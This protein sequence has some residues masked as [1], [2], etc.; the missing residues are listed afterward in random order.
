MKK[1]VG[2]RGQ[3]LFFGLLVIAFFGLVIG[4]GCKGQQGGGG[5]SL[6][7]SGKVL[8]VVNGNKITQSDLEAIISNLPPR[9]RSFYK[10][11]QAQKQLV[12][13][14][15]TKELLYHEAVKRGID[16]EKEIRNQM[17]NQ[18]R[19]VLIRALLDQVTEERS[20]DDL[21]RKRFE[22]DKERYSKP[23]VKASHI[24]I[25][26]Q[27]LANKVYQRAKKG[28]NFSKL[29]KEFSQDPSNKNKGGDLGFFP[30]ERMVKEFS[31]KAFNMKVGEI[32]EPVKTRYGYHIIKLT[33]KRESQPFEEVKE[34][35]ASDIKRSA[36]QEYIEELKNSA[37]IDIKIPE[38][39][40]SSKKL[41]VTKMPSS[42]E[43]K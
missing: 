28:E 10:S 17:E 20:T 5:F 33:E 32:S 19:E 42:S 18:R 7:K 27:A 30:K 1:I 29:A 15:I 3:N 21:L 34:R 24:L 35:V 40:A 39:S 41:P 37:K 2:Y 16:K 8:A 6:F 22:K 11:P 38:A 14:L 9:A 23:Q 13:N 12:D 4:Y 43:K 26:D 31:D 36:R 25:K